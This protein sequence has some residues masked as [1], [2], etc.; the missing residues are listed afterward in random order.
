MVLNS[1]DFNS[2]ILVLAIIVA[3]VLVASFPDKYRYSHSCSAAIVLF[4]LERLRVRAP[5]FYAAG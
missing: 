5:C 4:G 3:L 2:T 1:G